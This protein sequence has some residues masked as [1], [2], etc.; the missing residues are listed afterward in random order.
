LAAH[1]RVIEILHLVGAHDGYVAGQFQRHAFSRGLAG[2]VIGAAVAA[3]I[4][5]AAGQWL[6]G[7]DKTALALRPAQWLAVASLPLAGALLA[8]ATA[9]YTVLRSLRRIL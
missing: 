6:P 2:G 4:I 8:M 1:K 3:A 5:L 9:R 7:V